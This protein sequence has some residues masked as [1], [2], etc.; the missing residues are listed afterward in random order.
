MPLISK[1]GNAMPQ[2]P[3]RKLVP[4]AEAAKKQGTKVFHLNIGQP[5]IKTPQVAL[6]AIK[7]NT[8]EVLSYARS[9]GSETYRAKLAAYYATNNINVDA[10]NIIATTGGSEALLFTIGSI[11]DPGDEVIIPE[12]FYANYNGFSTASGVTVVPVISKIEDNFSLPKIEDFENLIT[13]KTKAILICNPG[14]PTGYLYSKEEILKLKEIVLKHDLFLIAD[15]VYR[16][17]V[18]DGNEHNSVMA[19]DGLE[20]NAIMI[21]SVSKRYSMC[22]ARIGCIVSKNEEFI[23]TAIKFAQARLSPPTY[24]LLASE[25]ALETPQSYFDN[26]IEEY[27]NRRNL[28]I[29]ELKKIAGVKVANPKGA[30]YCI[31]ELPVK[32]ADHFA[33]WI[34]EKFN[35]N[36]ETVMV[37]PA[38]GFYSTKG[39]GKNQVRIAYVLNEADLKRSV[40]I[41]KIALNKYNS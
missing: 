40:E 31:A 12:P 37:A 41:L 3:I 32:D 35:D 24:A 6:D 4:F 21:D 39:E 8:I 17:F 27:V 11:T 7:N 30:F 28:L 9:E 25:A 38:S 20:Q 1:K 19:I 5:D 13:P 36:N 34:L 26:V 29:S 15:E 23:T 16:E 14:N 10:N 18:Y 33:Q 2:S 22:G